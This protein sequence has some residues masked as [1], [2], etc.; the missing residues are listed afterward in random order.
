M[1]NEKPTEAE[2]QFWAECMAAAL[3]AIAVTSADLD[4]MSDRAIAKD[5]A[6]LA[7]AALEQYDVRWG[8]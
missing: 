1:S 3:G 2:R 6:D 8:K 4:Y 7:D 5:A